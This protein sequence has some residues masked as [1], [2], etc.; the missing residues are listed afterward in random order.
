MGSPRLH[1]VLTAVRQHTSET[2]PIVVFDLDSTL[3][4]TGHRH[5][6]ILTEFARATAKRRGRAWEKLR[7]LAPT[8]RADDF[9]YNVTDPL[10]ARRIRDPIL[11][12]ELGRFWAE[13]Y[14]RSDYCVV[15]EPA[16]GAVDY[17]RAVHEAGA[18]VWY[19][20]GRPQ[21][22][23]VRGTQ[24]SLTALGFPMD[25]RSRLQLR[26]AEH[27]GDK[28]FKVV[29]GRHIAGHGTVLGQ[30]ENEPTNANALLPIFPSALHFLVGDVHS[31]APVIAD[32]T[33]H[34][35]DDFVL[36]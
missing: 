18:L 2:T 20:T 6:R 3:L 13:R 22:A 32:A 9:G 15:D 10:H 36:P 29:A 1:D 11:E 35:T 23:M 30:F 4:C 31:A 21:A 12:R 5:L 7:D 25:A 24:D 28:D 8:L 16:P 34:R 19:L 26:P 14:F 27:K 33:I 17:V